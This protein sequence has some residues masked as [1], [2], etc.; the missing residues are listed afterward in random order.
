MGEGAQPKHAPSPAAGAGGTV[1][2]WRWS[3]SRGPGGT[4]RAGPGRGR[5]GRRSRR[6]RGR[7]TPQPYGA[8]RARLKSPDGGQWGRAGG[9]SFAYGARRAVTCGGVRRAR[10]GRTGR[11]RPLR[12]PP[13]RGHPSAPA[14][15]Q[16]PS[17]SR[18]PP[19]APSPLTETTVEQCLVRLRRLGLSAPL[20]QPCE[21]RV[22]KPYCGTSS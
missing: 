10:R 20:P 8:R 2:C 3:P 12:A 21:R 9:R 17:L 16:P 19:A 13:G 14:A 11:P 7:A 15:P 18:E 1:I 5:L 22:N 4:G 6:A